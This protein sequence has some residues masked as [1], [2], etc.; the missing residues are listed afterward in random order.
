MFAVLIGGVILLALAIV[1]I[2]MSWNS[3]KVMWNFAHSLWALI[4]TLVS[5]G[6]VLYV[7]YLL[8]D[9]MDFDALQNPAN[10]TPEMAKEHSLYMM[11]YGRKLFQTNAD[12][13]I[14]SVADFV[15]KTLSV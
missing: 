1:V 13:F 15:N 4:N 14:D 6:A 5:L 2:F 8:Y 11:Q 12:W 9:V 7:A 10:W 3:L